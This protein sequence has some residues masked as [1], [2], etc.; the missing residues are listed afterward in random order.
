MWKGFWLIKYSILVRFAICRSIP[1]IFAIKVES[2]QNSRRYLDVFSPSQI[3]G[4]GPS[5]TY[6]HFIT[7][8]SRHVG[9]KKFCED[10]STNEEVIG[11]QTPN[12]KFS[13]LNF[14]GGAPSQFCCAL[15][16]VG[17]S[18]RHVK[19]WG[20]APPLGSK[21]SL[22]KNVRLGGSILAPITLLFVDQSSP[23]FCYPTWKGL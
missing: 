19:I 22:L 6:T 12:F 16:S 8:A 11:A 2:C 3:S 23:N 7:P 10:T 15:A 14:L 5:K 21:Y 9:W 20:A 1:E 13:R 17:Q 4:G 18:V